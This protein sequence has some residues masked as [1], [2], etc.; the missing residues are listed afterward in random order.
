[1]FI[2][3]LLVLALA[4]S[5]ALLLSTNV[6]ARASKLKSCETSRQ[7]FLMNCSRLIPCKQLWKKTPQQEVERIDK[8]SDDD[9]AIKDVDSGN[10]GI[11][12]SRVKTDYL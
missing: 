4:G 9:M 7:T 8:C 5:A 10:T 11:N 3:K 12:I 2:L 1:M 6:V